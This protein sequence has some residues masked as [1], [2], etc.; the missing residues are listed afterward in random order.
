MYSRRRVIDLPEAKN[1]RLR[2]HLNE[3]AGAIAGQEDEARKTKVSA[4]LAKDAHLVEAA[5]QTGNREASLD[6]TVRSYLHVCARAHAD[7]KRIV[8]VNP[9]KDDE[10]ASAWIQAGAPLD[11]HRKLGHKP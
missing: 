1:D 3:C 8:W 4:A 6:E 2:A 7:L 10:Q 5:I 11:R 9:N